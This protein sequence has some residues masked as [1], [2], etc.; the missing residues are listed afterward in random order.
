MRASRLLSILLLLQTR[1]RM[2]A[3]ALAHE[4]EVS[5]RTIYRDIEQLSASEV[6]VYADRGPNGGFEL[7]DGYRTKLTGLSPAEAST[8]FLAGLPGPAAELGLADVLTTAQLKLTA[9]LPEGARATAKLVSARFHLDPV[10]WFKSA[11]DARYLPL[12]A[13]AVWHDNCIGIRYQR[14][15]RIVTR[16][17]QPLGLVL[18]GGV[19]YV[20]ARVGEQVRTYRV[21]NIVE[22]MPGDERFERPKEFDLV[23]F[24]TTA[25]RAYEVGM[26]RDKATLRV[27]PRA[28]MTLES[29]GSAVTEAITATAGPPDTGGWV[30]VVIPIESVDQATAELIRL[31]TGAEVLEPIELRHRIGKVARE[32]ARLY[33]GRKSQKAVSAPAAAPAKTKTVRSR[34]AR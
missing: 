25:A 5:I 19:W 17:V 30:R 11:E 26:Y 8:L 9:A 20:V 29:F 6:P 12:I 23:K 22:L 33:R 32:L 24:W 7:L 28:R 31:G 15:N 4:F 27:S 21:S 10:G 2:T 1:G 16:K 18:K 34:R 14:Y 13:D 3:Q